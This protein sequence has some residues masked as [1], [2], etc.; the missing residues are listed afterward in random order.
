LYVV[1]YRLLFMAAASSSTQTNQILSETID[2]YPYFFM[3]IT[4]YPNLVNHVH[5]NDQIN[6]V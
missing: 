4:N 6:E 3:S 1:D 5:Q 2:V